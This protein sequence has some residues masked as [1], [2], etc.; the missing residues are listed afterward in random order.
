MHLLWLNQVAKEL[1]EV[2][3]NWVKNYELCTW[4][5]T[6][7]QFSYL[8]D[9]LL[10]ITITWTVLQHFWYIGLFAIIIESTK[11]FWFK[12]SCRTNSL[13]TLF[14]DWVIFYSFFS[15]DRG[16][17][18]E[19]QTR[20][21]TFCHF[22][23]QLP[24]PFGHDSSALPAILINNMRNRLPAFSLTTKLPSHNLLTTNLTTYESWICLPNTYDY[25]FDYQVY[26]GQFYCYW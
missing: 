1:K 21:W 12:V 19:I 10:I 22:Y 14:S 25:Q 8:N 7:F 24:Q 3:Y 9:W 20:A 2:I 23:S 26:A 5:S 6:H 15:V 4:S 17:L 16:S 11:F 13:K 18:V